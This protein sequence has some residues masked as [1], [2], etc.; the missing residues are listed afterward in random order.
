M[1]KIIWYV[2]NNE[3]DSSLVILYEGLNKYSNF[4]Y[5][6]GMIDVE[7]VITSDA[8]I[9]IG[10]YRYYE[11]CNMV[12]MK[13]KFND[14]CFCF[15]H[16][17]N[18]R[19]GNFNDFV[20]RYKRIS[21]NGIGFIVSSNYSLKCLKRMGLTGTIIPFGVDLTKFYCIEKP[22]RSLIFGMCYQKR[23]AYC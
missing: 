10:S 12:R 6:K 19:G 4:E 8:D 5:V 14:K 15:V 7:E 2:G 16:G 13:N 9:V 22:V 1:G 21:N 23:K 3:P 20:D 18:T 17:F 11:G